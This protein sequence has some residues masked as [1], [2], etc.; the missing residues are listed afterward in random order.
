MQST[1][2]SSASVSFTRTVTL[3]RQDFIATEGQMTFNVT[4]FTLTDYYLL[5]IDDIIQTSNQS[6]EGNIISLSNGLP[7]GSRV[8]VFGI[9]ATVTGTVRKQEFTAVDGQTTFT[10]TTFTLSD[11]FIFIMNDVIQSE[12]VKE[13]NEIILGSGAAEGSKIIIYG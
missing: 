7:E 11:N 3:S 4:D 1:G 13:G 5:V 9:S 6:K 2:G 12:V 10:V 8:V